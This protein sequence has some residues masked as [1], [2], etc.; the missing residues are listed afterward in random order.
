MFNKTMQY[1]ATPGRNLKATCRQLTGFCALA[2]A[3]GA[4]TAHAQKF[5]I[6][7][8]QKAVLATSDGKKAAT[9]IDTKFSPVKEEL[10]K[11]QAQIQQ[12]QDAFTKGRGTM[13]QAALASAQAEIEAL[14]TTLKRKQEDAQQD[15]QDEE[16]KLLGAI[17]PKLQQVINE[18]A[19][20]NQINFVLDSSANPNNMIYGD[21]SLNIISPVV[22]AYE[23]ASA[24]ATP[25]AAPK[26]AAAMTPKA[27]AAA[28]TPKTS[29][30]TAP[31]TGTSA[32]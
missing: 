21:G 6:I 13:S 32:K 17:M 29:G 23:K 2:L 1:L 4:G 16:Q 20:A 24:S 19:T 14:T 28:T 9:A 31:K 10:D 22:Q 11:L 3:L 25:A 26:P 30:T 27:P 12:K 15:L 5:A 8:M 18:Y 7:D